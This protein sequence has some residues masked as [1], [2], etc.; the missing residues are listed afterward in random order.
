MRCKECGAVL[1]DTDTYCGKCGKKV[2]ID[3][4]PKCGE[5]LRPGMRFCVKCGSEVLTLEEVAGDTGDI[6]ITG[7]LATTDIPFD[8]IEANIIRDVERQLDVPKIKER[9]V[10]KI[11]KK[12]I[13]ESVEDEIEEYEEDVEDVEEYEEDYDEYYDEDID[14]EESSLG[15]R[16]LTAGIIV[17]GLILVLIVAIVFFNNRNSK[18]TLQES[19]VSNEIV[20]SEENQL[21][22]ADNKDNTIGSIMVIKDVNIRDNPSTDNSEVLDVARVGEEYKYFGYADGSENWIHIKVDDATEG[23]VYKDYVQIIE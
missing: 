9:P 15:S 23:Y 7:Q 14:E 4:C 11:E 12:Y 5:P 19:E 13:E 10:K 17:I 16:L 18:N 22:E 2:V 20:E 1:L 8:V 21:D 3:V 6:P